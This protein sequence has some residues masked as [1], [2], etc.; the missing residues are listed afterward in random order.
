ME[1]A[2][3]NGSSLTHAIHR[4]EWVVPTPAFPFEAELTAGVRTAGLLA[5][6][7]ADR[8]GAIRSAIEEKL[9]RYAKDNGFAIPKAAYVVAVTTR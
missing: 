2:G 4:I 3:F 6:Q 8:L 9:K 7:S 5:A 1:Q